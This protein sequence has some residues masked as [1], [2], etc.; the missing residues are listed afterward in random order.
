MQG[1]SNVAALEI[2]D[3]R[4]QPSILH[5]FC[6]VHCVNQFDVCPVLLWKCPKEVGVSFSRVI[7]AI[8]GTIIF[9][10][11]CFGQNGAIGMM[12]VRI[13]DIKCE[14]LEQT[15]RYVFPVDDIHRCRCTVSKATAI[16]QLLCG[17]FVSEVR[18]LIVLLAKLHRDQVCRGSID[19]IQGE[20]LLSSLCRSTHT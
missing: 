1:P 4:I 18:S 5:F 17:P 2:P 10:P 13:L 12:C 11:T 9:F 15:S 7:A 8:A 3:F 16:H 20:R 6:V 14:V 19:I